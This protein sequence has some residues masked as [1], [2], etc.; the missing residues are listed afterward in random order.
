M[1]TQVLRSNTQFVVNLSLGFLKI[2][3]VI[4]N[5]LRREWRKWIIYG[6]PFLLYVHKKMMAANLCSNGII[7]WTKDPQTWSI[8]SAIYFHEFYILSRDACAWQSLFRL[9]KEGLQIQSRSLNMYTINSKRTSLHH[10][11][12]SMSQVFSKNYS[13]PERYCKNNRWAWT[14]IHIFPCP[15][16][17][18]YC[19][20]ALDCPWAL[21]LCFQVL[22]SFWRVSINHPSHRVRLMMLQI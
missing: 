1:Y 18:I 4:I 12:L 2:P 5:E 10:Q 14:P 19:G 11:T 3:D 20:I 22:F 13:V 9:V 17:Y 21:S 7:I 15:R 8:Q 6:S 16:A